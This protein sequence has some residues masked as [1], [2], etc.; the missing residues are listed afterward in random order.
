[1]KE[2]EQSQFVPRLPADAPSNPH[3]VSSRSLVLDPSNPQPSSLFLP[4]SPTHSRSS[5]DVFVLH[6]G[7]VMF[8]NQSGVKLTPSNKL[9]SEVRVSRTLKAASAKRYGRPRKAEPGRSARRSARRER[10]GI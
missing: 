10:R 3:F 7:C 5:E 9:F 4:A 6:L 2:K 8:R 1:M